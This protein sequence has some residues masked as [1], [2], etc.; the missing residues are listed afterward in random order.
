L[1]FFFFSAPANPYTISHTVLICEAITWKRGSFPRTRARSFSLAWSSWW[2]VGY[3]FPFVHPHSYL[4]AASMSCCYA[5]T[6]P[7]AL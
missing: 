4:Q 1:I 2:R 7:A 3:C 6:Q 5:T